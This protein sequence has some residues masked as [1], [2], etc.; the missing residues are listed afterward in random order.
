MAV[1]SPLL[2]ADGM[3][4]KLWM[5]RKEIERIRAQMTKP[6][7]HNGEQY[8][9]LIKKKRFTIGEYACLQANINPS[10]DDGS[11]VAGDIWRGVVGPYLSELLGAVEVRKEEDEY[12]PFGTGFIDAFYLAG[13]KGK[14]PPYCEGIN[15]D[16][17]FPAEAY[18]KYCLDVGIPCLLDGV[19]INFNS[20][21]EAETDFPQ[22]DLPEDDLPPWYMSD[23]LSVVPTIQSSAVEVQAT[24]KKAKG[25]RPYLRDDIDYWNEVKRVAVLNG[26]TDDRKVVMLQKWMADNKRVV[27]RYETVKRHLK[28]ARREMRAKKPL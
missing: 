17:S 20:S 21:E 14:C 23:D 18:K 25:G 9:T 12:V 15:K 27:R 5:D 16:I 26:M 8:R 10:F 11:L 2:F 28:D 13:F 24:T 1:R 19:A 3:D 7:D 4:G 22:D 6:I